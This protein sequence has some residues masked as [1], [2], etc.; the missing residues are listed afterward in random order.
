MRTKD[1]NIMMKE[2]AAQS[3]AAYIQQLENENEKLKQEL[4]ETK[5][6]NE[7]YLIKIRSLAREINEQYDEIDELKSEIQA[8]KNFILKFAEYAANVYAEDVAESV[9]L[10]KTQIKYKNDPYLNY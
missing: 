1:F 7:L 2:S 4:A 9:R 3:D 5:R 6:F 10:Q 8:L